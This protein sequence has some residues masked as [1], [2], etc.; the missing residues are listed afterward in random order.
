MIRIAFLYLGAFGW[1]I[2]G[3]CE[4]VSGAPMSEYGLFFIIG[5]QSFTAALI[6]ERD[7]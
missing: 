5:F 6:L 4:F 7:A 1:V 2:S 3:F